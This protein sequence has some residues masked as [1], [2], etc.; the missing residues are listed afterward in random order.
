MVLLLCKNCCNLVK[1]AAWFSHL[2]KGAEEFAG[3]AAVLFA[4]S[5]LEALSFC[6]YIYR[7]ES[8]P[9]GY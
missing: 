9:E 5:D 8:A 4:H 7:Q 1:A 3:T 6:C 2:A